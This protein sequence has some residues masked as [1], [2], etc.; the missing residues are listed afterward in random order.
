MKDLP[1]MYGSGSRLMIINIY[2][3]QLSKFEK[4]GL[5]N[6]TEHNTLITEKL[7]KTT[8][9]RLAQLSTAYEASLTPAAELWRRKRDEGEMYDR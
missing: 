2:K 6:Y 3:E 5:G 1:L 9:K 7:I 4:I 8:E